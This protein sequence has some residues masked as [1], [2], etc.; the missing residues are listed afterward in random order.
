MISSIT[1]PI[2]CAVM[3]LIELLLFDPTMKLEAMI[4]KHDLVRKLL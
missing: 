3:G 1:L 2:F 4:P